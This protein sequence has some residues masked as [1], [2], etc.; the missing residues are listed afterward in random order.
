MRTERVGTISS[1]RFDDGQDLH[2]EGR[3][4]LEH[5][6]L[7]RERHDHDLGER[8]EGMS[9]AVNIKLPSPLPIKLNLGSGNSPI[10][11]CLNVDIDLSVNPDIIMDLNVPENLDVLPD[12]HFQEIYAEHCLEHIDD[13]FSTMKQLY[14]ILAADGLLVI[15]VPH[16]SLGFTHA[17]HKHGFDVTF[18]DYVDPTYKGGYI[19][20]PFKLERM[21]LTYFIRWDLKGARVKPWQLPLLKLLNSVVNMFANA[22]PYFCSRFWCYWVGGFEEIEFILRKIS[23]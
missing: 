4:E 18:P 13:V 22:Q 15:K 19:G 6:V 1:V 9:E 7:R 17:Q 11:D 23:R 12:C 10:K 14:R 2:V 5:S 20:A 8:K 16:R 21:K 3:S